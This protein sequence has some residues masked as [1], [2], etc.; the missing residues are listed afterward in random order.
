MMK[1]GCDRVACSPE[2]EQVETCLEDLTELTGGA[3]LRRIEGSLGHLLKI[4]NE[5]PAAILISYSALGVASDGWRR[6]QRARG[7]T[8]KARTRLSGRRVS[9]DRF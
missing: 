5:F 4:L 6:S 7:V 9:H 8:V 2:D 1:H 3:T